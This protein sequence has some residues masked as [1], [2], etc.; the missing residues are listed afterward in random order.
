MTG[1]CAGGTRVEKNKTAFSVSRD[2]KWYML[3]KG[4]DYRK[5]Y[6]NREYVVN[7]VS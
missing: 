1:F 2:K 7:M 6:G 3:N 4:G 5:W